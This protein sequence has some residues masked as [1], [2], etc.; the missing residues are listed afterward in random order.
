MSRLVLVGGG[1]GHVEVLRDLAEN[2]AGA[3]DATL[4]T[5]YPWLTYTGMVPGLFAGH[6]EID[7]CTIDLRAL[8]ERARVSLVQANAIRIDTADREVVCDNGATVPYEVLSLDV[9]TVPYGAD[10]K[11]VDRHAVVMRPLEKA[12]KG[13]SDVIVRAREGRIGAVTV[14]GGGAAGV[15]LALAMEYRLRQELGLAWAH[16]RVVTNTGLVVPEFPAGARAR[17]ER[18]LRRRNIGVHTGSAVTDVGPDYVRL[19]QGLEFSSDAVFW[20]TGGAAPAWIRLSGFSTDERGFLLTNDRLQ[21]VSHPDVFGIGDCASVEGRP[22]P[23][24][25]VFAV[26]AAPTLAANLRAALAGEKPK[27]HA[28]GA[29]Y[30]ALVSTGNRHAVGVW[31]GRSWEG[32]WV[33][34]WKDR[35]DRRFVG[36]YGTRGDSR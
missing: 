29:R 10:T 8:A 2:P 16:V 13:W 22:R 20:A 14:V 17:L 12:V 3:V 21:S 31:D 24:A 6:Y 4:V 34:S 1:H 28:T 33:W 32:D 30:L 27:P 7:Q 18:K 15:E 23:K 36:R 11:G 5:P 35:I 19:E 9:G 25:A 26:R